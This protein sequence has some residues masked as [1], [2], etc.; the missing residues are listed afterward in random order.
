MGRGRKHFML[1]IEQNLF[2]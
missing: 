2:L 1:H